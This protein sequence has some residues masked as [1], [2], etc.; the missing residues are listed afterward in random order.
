M[1][2]VNSGASERLK[3][4][5]RSLT[6][7]EWLMAAVMVLIAANAMFQAFT[8]TEAGG[9]PPW[10]TIVNFFSAARLEEWKSTT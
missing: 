3:A 10:L 6:W 1:E 4:T 5:F 8:G 9:N 7:Y 2:S